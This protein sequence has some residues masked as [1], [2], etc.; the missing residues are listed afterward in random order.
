VRVRVLHRV[1]RMRQ[2]DEPS[3]AEKQNALGDE[4]KRVCRQPIERRAFGKL[5]ESRR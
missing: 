4:A 2:T 3:V 1:Q 5:R